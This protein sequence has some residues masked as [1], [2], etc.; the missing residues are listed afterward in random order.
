MTT[1]I[2]GHKSPDTDAIASAIAYAYLK[3]RL[4]EDIEAGRLGEINSETAYALDY[5]K[6]KKPQLIHDLQKDTPVILMDHNERQQ[7]IDGLENFRIKEIIDHHKIANVETKEPI[8]FRTEPVG[9]TATIV[10]QLYK[11]NGIEVPEQEAGMML[12]AIIS[13]TLL[14]QSPTTVEKDRK[15]AKEL[16]AAAGVEIKT[17]GISLLKAGTDWSA[18]KDDDLV[19]TDMK[20]F[21]MK[22][23][24]VRIAQVNTAGVASVLNR[25][26]AL[27]A[28]M[29]EAVQ[30]EAVDLYVLMITD[31]LQA[32]SILL[33]AG[34][35]KAKAG[36][37]F[38]KKLQDGAV[39]LPGVISRKKQVVPAL[40][41]I[42]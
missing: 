23:W 7:S 16:A 5:F 4:G 15:A 13:D 1:F 19:R 26:E 29:E 22:G 10:Y 12:S 28:K 33:A 41:Q 9:C 8:Y 36:E 37:A 27:F 25:R 30:R 38:G 39:E 42:I 34:A 11:E 24:K 40:Q 6:K 17:Y 32:D 31:V 18:T 2:F 35:G 20:D 3:K 21:D 14:F